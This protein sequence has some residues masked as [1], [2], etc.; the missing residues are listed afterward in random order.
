IADS[1]RLA[2]THAGRTL[3]RKETKIF[4]ISFLFSIDRDLTSLATLNN[5]MTSDQCNVSLQCN[6]HCYIEE[7]Y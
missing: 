3:K 6:K 5:L 7:Y 4:L 1:H 2:N